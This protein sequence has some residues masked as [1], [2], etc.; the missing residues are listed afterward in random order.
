MQVEMIREI[1]AAHPKYVVFVGMRVSLNL[2]PNPE[3]TMLDWIE[4]YV[5]RCYTLTG[6]AD[7]YSLNDTAMR[8]DDE[9]A[10]YKPRSGNLVF[11]FHRTSDAPC[12]VRRAGR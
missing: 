5:Q 10:D 9:V 3:R 6:L 4:R 8:W 7:V 12:T 1:D 2:W 11:T